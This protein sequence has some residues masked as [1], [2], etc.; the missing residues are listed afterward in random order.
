MNEYSLYFAFRG[1]IPPYSAILVNM[2]NN[3]SLVGFHP[4]PLAN[5][6][7]Q[8]LPMF[9]MLLTLLNTLAGKLLRR[10]LS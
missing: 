7:K 8:S 9:T 4:P 6:T 5:N 2:A 3:I 1:N 10:P